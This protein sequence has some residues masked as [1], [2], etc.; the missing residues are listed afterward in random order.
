[1]SEVKE[2]SL[3]PAN[4]KEN[5]SPNNKV[6][7]SVQ[8]M[9]CATCVKNV[10]R[11]LKKLDG[12]KYV[13]VNLAT[14]KAVLISQEAI[15]MAKIKKAVSD[16]G[17]KVSEEMPTEDLIE[18]RFKE[19]R[20][21][22]YLSLAFTIPLMVLMI[23]NMSGLNIPFMLFIELI[24]AGA[25][26]LIPG[27]KTLKSAWIALS[28]LHTNM[29]TL[30]SLGAISAWAT[31]LLAIA[32]L[33]ILSF[34]TIAA[35]LIT[36]N[37]I[38]RYI[39]ARMKHSA[40]REI[41]LLL[42]MKVDKANV[43]TDEGV[44]ELPI[45][46]VKIGDLILVRTGEK[47]PLDGA[48]VEG[49]ASI[50]ESMISGEPLP[51]SKG[52]KDSVV[53]G[54]IVES[55]LLK[56]KVE[57]VGEDTFLNQMIKLVEEAQS[58]KVPIQA[59][60]DRITLYFI[61]TVFSLAVL[62][63]ILWF[64]QYETFQP[65]LINA[66]NIIPWVLTD[67]GPLSTAIF[68]FVATLVIACPCAL[69]LA[70]PMAL[71]AASS[72]SAKKG[73]IIK[74]GEA[75][76]MAKDIDTILMDKTGT[77]T[78]GQPSVIE[79]N[80]DDETF[81][82]ISEIEKNST[83]PLAKAIVEYAHEH[84]KN[85]NIKIEEIEEIT[86]KGIV[87]TYKNNKYYIGKPRDAKP[88]Q[89]FME[90]AETVIEVSKNEKIVGYIRIADEIKSDAVEAIKKLKEMG[91]EPIMVTGDNENTARAVA[92]KVGINKVFANISPQN[93]VEIVRKYQIEGKR[94]AM[95]G[96]G[97][98]DAAAL[99]SSDMGIAIGNGTDLAIES[100]DVIISQGEISKVIDAIKISEIT[101]KKIK[102]NLFWAFF[103]NIIAI[104]LA[105][106]AI[107]HPAIAEIAMLFSSINVIYNSSRI[108]KKL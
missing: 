27:R 20:K 52:E 70:T 76:Q 84:I 102:Q 79:H 81:L 10:E 40:S 24:G 96:D 66:S 59:L 101:F 16:V 97:I 31:T 33:D 53:S 34:G 87:G 6:S 50:N 47:I 100:A 25:T 37:L 45:D 56:I 13:S 80:L 38:G 67:A 99:K 28:H 73:L 98:N 2:K 68:S 49:Q 103:Y 85:Q 88:Y 106:T 83:H 8:G 75:I 64:F 39:E 107:L 95:I 26:I 108:T 51:V 22:M 77:L 1:M 91:M 71:V 11:A 104:P 7:F 82:I 89:E 58:S 15:P 62:S 78:K 14:E 60:A 17:Y 21:D 69:G 65:F 94:V 41:K 48:I 18:K 57:K 44:V 93:K 30:I 32:G 9:T 92:K 42:S 90:N 55:G 54:T 36:L 4:S 3:E 5:F 63:G 105:M 35:M 29:D 46:T 43:I 74:N 61:P 72:V 86:G 23:L 19:S 12:V